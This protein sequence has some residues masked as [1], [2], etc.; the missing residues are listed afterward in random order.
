MDDKIISYKEHKKNNKGL[1]PFLLFGAF[2]LILVTV[3]LSIAA[4]K[5][6]EKVNY[7]QSSAALEE[8]NNKVEDTKILAVLKGIDTGSGTITLLDIEDGQDII[9]TLTGGTNVVDKYEKVISVSQLN[10]GEIVDAYYNKSSSV[11]SKLQISNKAWEY[12]GVSNWSMDEE[13]NIFNIAETKYKYSA[14]VVIFKQKQFLTPKDLDP[15]DELVVKGYNKEVWSIQVS[16]GHGTVTFEDYKDFIGGTVY[17]GNSEILP[18]VSDMSILVKEGSYDVTMEKG[19]LKGSKKAEV[20]PFQDTVINMG[21]FKL[22]PKKIGKVKFNITPEGA[23]LFINEELKDYSKALELNYGEYNIK[24]ALGGY[25]TYSGKL[26]IIGPGKTVSIDLVENQNTGDNTESD[27]RNTSETPVKTE[28]KNNSSTTKSD[29]DGRTDENDTVDEKD[30]DKNYDE[31]KASENIYVQ[32]PKGASIY[33][34]GQF[35]GTVPV[36]FP[37]VTGTHY[38]TLIQ[39]N[40]Q[41]KTYTVEIEDDKEDV[42]YSF[43]GL[44]K[45]E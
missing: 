29:S 24:V 11:V 28:D 5:S 4:Q 33:F 19:T 21:E 2:F 37:K 27:G 42:K 7:K 22:P 9:L 31:V 41:T 32:E 18:I 34:D 38:I 16:R 35:K 26:E 20:V 6:S 45:S 39:A 44:D 14:G 13:K 8:S 1:F 43:S 40:H 10:L 3:V 17:I 25:I 23:D 30:T 36:S 15:K 12:K